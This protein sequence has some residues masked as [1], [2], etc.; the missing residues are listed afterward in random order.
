MAAAAPLPCC[1]PHD[2][3]PFPPSCSP[4]LQSTV[5]I[6]VVT[7]SQSITQSVS[8]VQSRSEGVDVHVGQILRRVHTAPH[9]GL[10]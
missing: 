5:C 4:N 6:Q 9:Y 8:S 2:A 10:S 3:T 7:Q 1:H